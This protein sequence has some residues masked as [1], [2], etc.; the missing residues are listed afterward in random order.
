MSVGSPATATHTASEMLV[1][2]TPAIVEHDQSIV[3]DET[4]IVGELG[5]TRYLA[6]GLVLPF[7]VFDTHIRYVDPSSGQVVSIENPDLHHRNEVLTGLGDPWLLARAAMVAAGT[8]ISLR[9]GVTVPLGSTVP[10]PFALGDMGISHEH[11][12]FGTGTFDPVVGIDGYRAFGTVTV[13]AY[14]LTVQSLYENSH[15]YKAGNRY[16]FGAGAASNLGTTRWRFRAT[17]ERMSET[18]ESWSGVVYTTEGNIGRVDVLAGI[19]AGFAIDDDWRAALALK[20]PLYTHVVGGQ[21]DIPAFVSLTISTHAHLWKRKVAPG[22]GA[23]GK[24]TVV[25]YWATWCKP[26]H[27]L[28]LALDD[29]V[30]RHP[31]DVVVRKIDV[32][33]DAPFDLPHL[34]VLGRDGKLLWERGGSPAALAA[35]VEDAITGAHVTAQT[36]PPAT[37]GRKRFAITVTDS[38]YTPDRIEIPRGEPVVLVFTRTSETTCAVD[39]HFT[40]PDGTRID[41]RLPLGEHVEI[42]LQLDA[43]A[44][45]PYECGMKMNHGVIIVR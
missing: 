23:V 33:A 20:V 24:I 12:Q 13:E 27:E 18:A 19:E 16:A 3:N 15:G 22:E 4:R 26:C 40:L 35:G 2:G 14:A 17:L 34:Q 21:V 42:P 7:R 6:A 28:E 31:D 25:D 44:E 41:R 45:I 8:T 29:I 11:T 9:A 1:G 38:G 5:I 37:D 32:S 43:P 36:P 30:R 39:V 10:D